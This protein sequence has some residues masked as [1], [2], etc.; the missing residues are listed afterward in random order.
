MQPGKWLLTFFFFLAALL[1]VAMTAN[2]ALDIYGLYRD[3]RAGSR[4]A[5]GDERIAK[6]LLASRYVPAN[7][8][9]LLLGPSITANWRTNRMASCRCYNASLN[10]GNIVEEQAVAAQ[11]LPS[12]HIK[13]AILLIH[14]S[15]TLSHDFK[16]AEMSPKQRIAALGSESLLYAYKD[17][18]WRITNP[19]ETYNDGFG[20][21]YWGDAHHP[22]NEINIGLLRPG[23]PFDVDPEALAVYH[24]LLE[25]LQRYG[26]RVLLVVPPLAED[27]LEQKKL[28]FNRYSE[29]IID[30]TPSPTPV[31][32][33]TT[34]AYRSFR[35]NPRNF[36]DGVHMTQ[37]GA[38]IITDEVDRY[39]QRPR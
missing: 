5:L 34:P 39:L 24:H 32:D 29:R 25:Q 6:Y 37:K 8:D 33:F 14:P 28:Y 35:E 4:P 30:Q 23:V 15:L 12:G 18:F 13:L 10:G 2:Y 36:T 17:A 38:N 31:L 1:A 19:H 27:L 3:E 21:A 26:V 20:A 7:F 11:A 22:L 16:T 9:G